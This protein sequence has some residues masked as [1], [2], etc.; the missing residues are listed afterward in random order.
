MNTKKFNNLYLFI[1][2]FP[3]WL[4][5]SNIILSTKL[6]YFLPYLLLYIIF[7]TYFGDKYDTKFKLIFLSIITVFALDQNLQFYQN[8]I[9]PNFIFLTNNLPNIYFADL[10][11]IMSLLIITI[12]IFFLLKD[13]SIKIFFSFL[14]VI[15]IFKIFQ[16]IDKPIQIYNFNHTEKVKVKNYSNKKV[17]FMIFDEMSG[18]ESTEKDFEY[19]E[20]FV[21]TINSFAF[22]NN[23]KLYTNAFSI[24]SNTANSIPFMLNFETRVPTVKLRKTFIKKSVSMYNDYDLIKNRLF[25]KFDNISVI[26]NVHLNFCNQLN[27]KKC[28]QINPYINNTNYLKGFKNNLFTNFF[29][30]WNLDGSSTA[31]LFFKTS[32]LLNLTDSIL[33]PESHKIFLPLL[34]STIEKDVK[35]NKF[36]LIFAHILAPHVPYGFNKDCTYDGNKS[37]LNTNMTSEEKY[38]QHNLERI[39][40][41]NFMTNF[42]DNIKESQ[43]YKNLDIFIMSDHGSRITSKEDYTSILMTKIDNNK[44]EI[45]KDKTLLHKELKEIFIKK[46]K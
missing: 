37:S 8:F 38:I 24:S 21:K 7:N 27:V 25:E 6:I 5:S 43:Q 42:F 26:Q 2:L 29:S 9:K 12:I 33:E 18:V 23:L 3:S 30:R 35:E 32:R 40:M 46:Y 34:L 16:V 31:R 41:I 20:T 11:L 14:L 36:D 13:K 17:L 45:I 44:F 28:Y 39:C 1:C 4:L 22:Q 19:G 15:F 10:L